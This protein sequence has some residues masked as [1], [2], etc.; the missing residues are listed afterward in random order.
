MAIGTGTADIVEVMIHLGFP[1]WGFFVL[2]FST[3]TSQLVNNY[4]AGLG[5]SNALNLN[6]DKGRKIATA[7]ATIL[8]I[9]LSLGGILERFTDLYSIT[10][11][12]FPAIAAV[13]F[14]H[15]FL[16]N[17]GYRFPEVEWNWV[18]TVSIIL[19]GG[20]GFITT[21]ILPFGLP[22]VQTIIIAFLIY[23]FRMKSKYPLNE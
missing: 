23:Y 15:F 13:L 9:G 19:G 6:S 7:G 12:I 11:L 1:I 22:F 3:W 16:E 5:I 14:G 21:Y 20:I 8:A 10:G 4:S 2:W 17:K 18:A